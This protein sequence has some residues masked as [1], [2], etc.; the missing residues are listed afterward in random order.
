M[1]EYSL[2]EISLMQNAHGWDV[3]HMAKA[4]E[5]ECPVA[6]AAARE[7][8]VDDMLRDADKVLRQR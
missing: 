7:R 5:R 2:G 1:C 3:A 8:I 6:F 4:V